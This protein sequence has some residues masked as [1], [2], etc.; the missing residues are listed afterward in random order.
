MTGCLSVH[1]YVCPYGGRF[2]ASRD[3]CP[4]F[5]PGQNVF[6]RPSCR[7]ELH[8][9]VHGSQVK[10]CGNAFAKDAADGIRVGVVLGDEAPQGA[11]AQKWQIEAEED[12]AGRRADK[13]DALTL[14]GKDSEYYAKRRARLM[15]ER[16]RRANS[17]A[18]EVGCS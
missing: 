10:C 15:A 4:Y 14:E 1:I 11:I 2:N 6:M 17:H 3:Q 16:E 12:E 7:F 9:E 8:H 5:E 13:R 18:G